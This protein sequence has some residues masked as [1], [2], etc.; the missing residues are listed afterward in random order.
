MPTA[1]EQF[2]TSAVNGKTYVFGG[3]TTAVQ[4]EKTILK[5]LAT[6]EVYAPTTGVWEQKGDMPI[7]RTVISPSALNG[8]IYVILDRIMSVG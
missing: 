2:S 7:S 5:S 6:V 4:R 8:K 1:R 3:F